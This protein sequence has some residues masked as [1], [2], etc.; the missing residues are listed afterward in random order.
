MEGTLGGTIIFIFWETMRVSL[1]P[2]CV[3]SRVAHAFL[4]LRTGT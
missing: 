1:R 4:G 2:R 3:D